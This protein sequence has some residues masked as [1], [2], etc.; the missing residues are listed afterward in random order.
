M[1]C[2]TQAAGWPEL[3]IVRLVKSPHIGSVSNAISPR[4]TLNHSVPP[5][6]LA[7]VA[8]PRNCSAIFR[9]RSPG[10]EIQLSRRASMPIQSTEHGSSDS[11]NQSSTTEVGCRSG[12]GAEIRLDSLTDVAHTRNSAFRRQTRCKT[13][14][15]GDNLRTAHVQRTEIRGLVETSIVAIEHKRQR[16]LDGGNPTI[17]IQLRSMSRTT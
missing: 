3:Q 11:A 8:S 17:L 12:S 5:T 9:L 4:R 2:S 14:T 10:L 1:A 6:Y 7:V 16:V 13:A 15:S